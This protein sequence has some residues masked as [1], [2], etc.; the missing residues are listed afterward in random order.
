MVFDLG[1][2]TIPET[3]PETPYSPSP[4]APG[5]HPALSCQRPRNN[6]LSQ[7]RSSSNSPA[8][9]VLGWSNQ[10]PIGNFLPSRVATSAR[11]TGAGKSLFREQRERWPLDESCSSWLL[12]TD[13]QF[14]SRSS[15]CVIRHDTRLPIIVWVPLGFSVLQWVGS[16]HGPSPT[17]GRWSIARF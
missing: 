7:T 15:R 16:L 3:I 17:M 1:L 10:Y 11:S 8:V 13:P 5:I 9:K 2:T 4:W 12:M 6:S 14:S